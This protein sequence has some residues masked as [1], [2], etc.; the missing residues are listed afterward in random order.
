MNANT[1]EQ[2][3]LALL[4]GASE[5][6]GRVLAPHIARDGY[7]LILVARNES[8]LVELARELEGEHGVRVE[9]RPADL[10]DAQ[11]QRAV[12][13]YVR[14]LPRLTLL[15]NNAAFSV[16]GR[17]PDVPIDSIQQMV[18]LN[19]GALYMLSHAALNNRDFRRGGTLLNIGSIGG[20][21]PLPFDAVYASTKAAINLFSKAIAYEVKKNPEIDVHV[22][23]ARLGGLNTGWADRAVGELKPGEEPN[24]AI[25]MLMNDPVRA[26]AVVWPQTRARQR[27]IVYD[28]LS[29]RLQDMIFSRL[30]MIGTATT[31]M[32]NSQESARRERK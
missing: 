17:L 20:S 22:Q 23:V 9:V 2:R 16:V 15:V 12:A 10:S 13:E 27:H 25:Q 32:F 11:T 4:T 5:G 21:W 1:D 6:F 14:E 24:P 31:H 19:L 8:R 18:S 7:D 28:C 30:P 26:A 3:P 29:A